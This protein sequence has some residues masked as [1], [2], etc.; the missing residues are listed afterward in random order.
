ML[1]ETLT[2]RFFDFNRIERGQIKM[3]IRELI[4]RSTKIRDAYHA[5]EM[6]Q[7][8]KPWTSEQD[9]LAFLSDAGLVGELVMD[10]QGSWPDSD[11]NYKL[12]A[13][14]AEC[15]WWL[16]SLAEENQVDLEKSLDNFLGDREKHLKS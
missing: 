10:N 8:G 15:M 11:Q 12:D 2:L 4:Q 7:D 5:L 13:K 16:S 6:K 3:E 1:G 9:A 14:I